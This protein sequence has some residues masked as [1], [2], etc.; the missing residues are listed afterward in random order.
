MNEF[1]LPASDR[2]RDLGAL[3]DKKIKKTVDFQQSVRNFILMQLPLFIAPSQRPD[4]DKQDA[5]NNKRM[6]RAVSKLR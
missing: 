6:D 4:A 2:V 1:I 3:F 5:V